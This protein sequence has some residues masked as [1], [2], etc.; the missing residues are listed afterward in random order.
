MNCSLTTEVTEK[1]ARAQPDLAR[2][3]WTNGL[4]LPSLEKHVDEAKRRARE[5]L[6]TMRG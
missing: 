1:L 4:A 3:A 6:E 2:Q 5:A